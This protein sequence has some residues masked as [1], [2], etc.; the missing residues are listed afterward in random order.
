[1]DLITPLPK[2]PRGHDAIVVF[3]D[4]LTK[5]VVYVPCTSTITAPQ[6]AALFI[7]RIV[8]QHGLPTTI[9]SDRD[10]RFTSK[11]WRATFSALGTKLAMSTAYHPETD[12]QTERANRTLEETLR[13]YVNE[14]HSDW[15]LHLAVVALA[16]NSALHAS[17]RYSPF[18]LN[19]GRHP[20]LPSSFLS[21]SCP[22]ASELVNTLHEALEGAK[23]NL[24]KA[25]RAQKHFADKRRRPCTFAVGDKVLLSTANLNMRSPGQVRK[26]QPKWVGPFSIL[27][28]F[29]TSFELELP[30][31]Y[32]RIHPV[33]H[34]SVLRPYI[35]G[36]HRFPGREVLSRP[37]PI[38]NDDG[39][40]EFEIDRILEKKVTGKGTRQK[41]LYLVKWK[42]YP[43]SDNTWEPYTNLKDTAA[44]ARYRSESR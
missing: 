12:G 13:A 4:K 42:G 19:H 18:F 25:Q 10:P 6:L 44:L 33:F 28:S 2:T 39:E 38:L 14:R 5:M 27:R 32:S 17:T 7:E 43:D 22:A 34:A 41:T 24:A 16:H 40:E 36:T 29:G 31:Q 20:R 3:V 23:S 1:M 37:L 8:S 35:D 26:L 15:D 11:F 21:T 9:V 30:A